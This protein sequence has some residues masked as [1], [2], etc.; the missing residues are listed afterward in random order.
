MLEQEKAVPS[1]LSCATPCEH[2]WQA[3]L[4]ELSQYA[5]SSQSQIGN[6]LLLLKRG[7]K[8][9]LH[10]QSTTMQVNAPYCS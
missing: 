7:C 3:Q 8:Y 6:V 2:L 9:I 10:K 5:A 1:K 4:Q